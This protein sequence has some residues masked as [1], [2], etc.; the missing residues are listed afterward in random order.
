[1]HV[2]IKGQVL[3]N[4]RSIEVIPFRLPVELATVKCTLLVNRTLDDAYS[5]STREY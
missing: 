5:P 2:V 1:M 3:R 4:L